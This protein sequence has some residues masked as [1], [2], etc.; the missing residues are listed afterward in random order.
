MSPTF[1]TGKLKIMLEP[2]EGICDKAIDHISKQVEKNQELD[3]KPVIQGFTL[4]SIAK[5]AFGLETNCH[6]GENQEFAKTSFDVL[7]QF[8]LTDN[9]PLVVMFNFFQHLPE[10]TRRLGFW[11]ESAFKIRKMT[12]DLIEDR[13]AKNIEVGDFVDR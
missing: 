7:N 11:P 6:R 3:M 2:I 5:V 1:T 12:H 13:M 10:V 4:D 8:I 9:F